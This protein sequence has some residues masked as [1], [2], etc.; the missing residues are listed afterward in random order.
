MLDQ[1]LLRFLRFLGRIL[2]WILHRS[3]RWSWNVLGPVSTLILLYL[4]IGVVSGIQHVLHHESFWK[5]FEWIQP[6]SEE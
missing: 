3:L 6:P 1:L 5:G 4:L 2:D